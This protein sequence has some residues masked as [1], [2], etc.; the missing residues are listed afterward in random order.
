MTGNCW[1]AAFAFEVVATVFFLWMMVMA[2]QVT[3]N[4]FD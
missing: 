4:T 1:K 2:Y 3:Q